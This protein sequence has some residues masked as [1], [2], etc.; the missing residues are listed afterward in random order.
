[1]FIPVI[2]I[3]LSVVL[4]YFLWQKTN[5]I[6]YRSALIFS[7]IIIFVISGQYI[8]LTKDEFLEGFEVQMPD[9]DTEPAVINSPKYDADNSY[10]DKDEELAVN[11]GSASMPDNKPGKIKSIAELDSM[12]KAG[13]SQS[14]KNIPAKSRKSDTFNN[15]IQK[16]TGGEQSSVFNPQIILMGNGGAG[17]GTNGTSNR[18]IGNSNNSN[19]NA[20][21]LNAS[22]ST[23]V[24][25]QI[26]S[27]SQSSSATTVNN[28]GVTP[29]VIDEY[30][31]PR[32][33][34]FN[35]GSGEVGSANPFDWMKD[36]LQVQ[37]SRTGNANGST[38]S[39]PVSKPYADDSVGRFNSATLTNRTYV[40][41]MAYMP[42][43]E[44]NMPQT[45]DNNCR[46][47]CN[48]I[49]IN[50][51]ALPIGIMDHGTPVFALEIGNDGT[52]AKTEDDVRYTN[53][54]SIMPKFEYREYVDCPSPQPTAGSSI[55]TTTTK[56]G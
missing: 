33:D 3:I 45:R 15:I 4:A 43:A 5:D 54:G 44:W 1:M 51:R 14:V 22:T 18:S 35:G 48:N 34:I 2:C 53:V 8:K 20:F 17:S 24:N 9:A 50:T 49:D 7:V 23:A 40:P 42:P 39:C 41:G 30:L 36:F 13:L 56:A 19:A 38:A 25:N 21:S 37:N 16:D 46:Q 26:A 47:V 28:F 27:S 6:K 29:R 12:A 52:I 31:R 11:G 55:A 10:L 32:S